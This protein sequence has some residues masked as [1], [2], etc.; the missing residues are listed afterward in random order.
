[1]P[2]NRRRGA[3]AFTLVEMLVVIGVIGVI[4]GL[5]VPGLRTVQAEAESVRC[6]SNLRNLGQILEASMQQRSGM[7]VMVDP[8]PAVTPEG[9]IGGLPQRLQGFVEPTSDVWTCPA[10]RDDYESLA[11]GTSYSYVPGIV[12][13]AP[14][15][16]FRVVQSLVPLLDDPS[17]SPREFE[18]R[19]LEAESREV[20]ATYRTAV[21]R[22]PLLMDS[23]DRHFT[24][25][26][27][28]NAAFWDGS[29]DALDDFRFTEEED[30]DG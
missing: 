24:G 26:A 18:R 14:Q 30:P 25:R 23:A 15:I 2:G 11:T 7:L 22:M 6:R 16:Q 10:D 12:R 1:M 17:I 5:V 9:P 20:T 3:R 13:Y 21:E 8:L 29:V 28:R 19:R 27:P 4:I